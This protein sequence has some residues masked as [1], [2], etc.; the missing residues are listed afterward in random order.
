VKIQY[1]RPALADL[2]LI[3]DTPFATRL[4]IRRKCLDRLKRFAQ[5]IALNA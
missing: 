4:A 5:P 3:L 1:T 2:K